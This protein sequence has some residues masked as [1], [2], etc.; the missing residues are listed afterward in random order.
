MNVIAAILSE[1]L[2]CGFKSDML[3]VAS[4]WWQE[5]D[6]EDWQRRVHVLETLLLDNRRPAKTNQGYFDEDT[7]LFS[8]GYYFAFMQKN[9]YIPIY[10]CNW[11]LKMDTSKYP[12]NKYYS[13][14]FKTEL[15]AMLWAVEA[16]TEYGQW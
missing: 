2:A 1:Y 15:E 8:V 6:Y 3:N 10:K 13:R 4:D 16:L 5:N 11:K 12:D 14:I 9:D 7:E